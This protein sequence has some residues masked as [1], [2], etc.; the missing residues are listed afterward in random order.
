VS[1]RLYWLLCL[2]A[3]CAALAAG[4]FQAQVR[5]A[6]CHHQ[7]VTVRAPSHPLSSEL[8][9]YWYCPECGAGDVPR[10]R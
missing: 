8:R 1:G 6:F 3:L 2:L 7:V 10:W 5:A 9:D 4:P